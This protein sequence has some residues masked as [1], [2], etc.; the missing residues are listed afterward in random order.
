MTFLAL[1]AKCGAVR[2]RDLAAAGD[3]VA[4]EH[5]AQGEAGEAHPGVGR[6]SRVA[7]S[8]P[9]GSGSRHRRPSAGQRIV[10]KSLWLNRTWTRPSLARWRGSAEAATAGSG[11]ESKGVSGAANRP[12]WSARNRSQAARSSSVGAR[13]RT[14]SNAAAMNR[15]VARPRPSPD[16]AASRR[17]DCDGQRAVGQ[18][19]G[20]LG[21]HALDPAVAVVGAGRVED[22]EEHGPLLL[23]VAEVE[24]PP[25][26]GHRRG[27]VE[28]GAAE[29]RVERAGGRTGGCRGPPRPPSAGGSS[30]SSGGSPGRTRGSGRRGRTASTRGV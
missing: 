2:R 30:A 27:R 8:S 17:A 18:G 21:H 13:P 4:V 16:S 14:A 20:L 28:V 22:L 6:G 11:P 10:T 24:A 9:V 5:R 15:R 25:P 12:A 1:G 23:G 26:R 19:E 3:A 7:W 29:R